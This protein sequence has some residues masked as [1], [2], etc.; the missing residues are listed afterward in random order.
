MTFDICKTGLSADCGTLYVEDKTVYNSAPEARTNYA[1]FLAGFYYVEGGEDTRLTIDNTLPE[2]VVTWNVTSAGD[3]YHYF[4][5]VPVIVWQP[6]D[7]YAEGD[8]V[9]E[10]SYY[11][12]SLG[13]TNVGYTP[14]DTPE[15]WWE[16]VDDPYLEITNTAGDTVIAD[17]TRQDEFSLCRADKCYKRVVH[18]SVEAGCED[19][20]KLANKSFMRVDALLQDAYILVAQ[21]NYTSAHKLALL[22]GDICNDLTDCGC[23]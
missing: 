4:D 13:D 1:L 19:C 16:K 18:D 21:T 6:G 11:W 8:I 5:L 14:T 12:K 3:G 10:N 2:T 17:V 9:Y 7:T 22:L 20:S 23:S 15:V